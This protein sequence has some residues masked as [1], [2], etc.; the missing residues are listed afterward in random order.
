MIEKDSS[1]WTELNE[2]IKIEMIK[3]E[4]I[5]GFIKTLQSFQQP[6]LKFKPKDKKLRMLKSRHA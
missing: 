4:S 1:I 3:I 5:N 2:S 6:K